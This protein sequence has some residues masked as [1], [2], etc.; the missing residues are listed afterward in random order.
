MMPNSGYE[1]LN[2]EDA[3]K[4]RRQFASLIFAEQEPA[5]L[6]VW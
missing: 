6:P 5:M 4:D 1:K 3:R 2:F